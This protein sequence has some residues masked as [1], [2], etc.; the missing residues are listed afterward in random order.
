MFFLQVPNIY[1]QKD[2][3]TE[4][5]V[6]GNDNRKQMKSKYLVLGSIPRTSKVKKSFIS[7]TL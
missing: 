1:K 2:E 4:R 7:A 3:L 6:L 5:Q